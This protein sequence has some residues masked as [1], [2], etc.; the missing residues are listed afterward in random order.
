MSLLYCDQSLTPRPYGGSKKLARYGLETY[1]QARLLGH[2]AGG[3]LWI[4]I[5]TLVSK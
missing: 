3:C 1:A 2:S 4:Y 5:V